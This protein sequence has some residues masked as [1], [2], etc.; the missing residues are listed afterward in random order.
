M[1]AVLSA[2]ILYI[3]GF[4]C[5][6]GILRLA[7]RHGIL[8]ADQARY[9]ASCYA[10]DLAARQAQERATLEARTFTTENAYLAGS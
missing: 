9:E 5:L 1:F 6:Y 2:V 8:D 3:C 4:P 7:I 10:Q